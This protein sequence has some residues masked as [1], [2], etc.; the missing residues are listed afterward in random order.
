MFI[1]QLKSK[2]KKPHHINPIKNS[3]GVVSLLIIF[4]LL[5]TN[6]ANAEISTK[7]PIFVVAKV[8]NQAITNIDLANRYNLV[9][10]ISKIKFSNPQEKQIVLN[11]IL[12]KM[13][14]EELQIKEAS[15][16]EAVL[17]A[18]NLTNP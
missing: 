12:Q 9:L 1:R 18:K 4:L 5:F 6:H 8:N 17:D 7:K 16:L 2:T 11:Q 3:F 15:T 10:K 14:D 13:I